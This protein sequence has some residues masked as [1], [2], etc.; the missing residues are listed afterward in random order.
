MNTTA[1]TTTAQAAPL[2]L[3]APDSAVGMGWVCA[4]LFAIAA[5]AGAIRSL[6][7]RDPPLR[8]EFVTRLEYK[9]DREEAAERYERNRVLSDKLFAKVEDMGRE[10]G[11]TKVSVEKTAGDVNRLNSK[12]DQL[13]LSGL[14]K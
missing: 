6:F 8:D 1:T 11:E 12:I 2:P 4:A 13:L 3:P 7:R 10:I 9:R 14:K 5:G